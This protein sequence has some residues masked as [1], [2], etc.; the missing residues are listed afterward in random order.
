MQAL[1]AIFARSPRTNVGTITAIDLG[2]RGVSGRLIS[3]TLSG[4]L[5]STTVSGEGFRSI[6]NEGRPTTDPAM[7]STLFATAPIP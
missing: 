6:F 5:G 3:V 2:R 4:T 7:R 1:S